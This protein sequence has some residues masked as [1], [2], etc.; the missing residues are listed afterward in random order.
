MNVWQ[1]LCKFFQFLDS[2]KSSNFEYII[3]LLSFVF[4]IECC[5]YHNAFLFEQATPAL[6]L[7]ATFLE[8]HVW[9]EYCR[10]LQLLRS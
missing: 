5:H 6:C 9:S 4:S 1:D 2:F 3:L 7:S 10:Q 8:A